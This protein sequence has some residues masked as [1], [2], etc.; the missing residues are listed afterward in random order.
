MSRLK[1]FQEKQKKLSRFQALK[2]IF[3]S[4]FM[5]AAVVVIAVV[6]IPKSPVGSIE[7]INTFNDAIS[8]TI[9]ITDSDNA[10]LEGTLKVELTNQF[11]TYEKDLPLGL[12][13]GLFEALQP[14]TPYTLKILA[15]KGY[16]LEVLDSQTVTTEPNP[17]GA[18]TGYNLL[19]DEAEYLIDYAIQYYIS[20]PEDDYQQILLRYAT[21]YSSEEL[22]YN[23]TE[24][25]LD[26]NTRE[27]TITSIYNYNVEVNLIL[28]AIN[29]D[30]E[31]IELDNIVFHTPYKI[32]ASMEIQQLTN[33]TVSFYV[34]PDYVDDV[35]F[36]LVLRQGRFIID[37][38][39]FMSRS[40][41]PDQMQDFE[42]MNVYAFSDLTPKKEYTVD[43]VA[44]YQDPYTLTSVD[45]LISSVDFTTTP[46]FDY[47]LDIQEF[48]DYYTVT[49]TTQDPELFYDVGYYTTYVWNIDD[50]WYDTH[51]SFAFETIGDTRQVSFEIYKST[52]PDYKI[53][54][55]I[56]HSD[57]Y[58]DF[59]ILD[60]II[61]QQEG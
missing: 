21:K 42:Q 26:E 53:E 33:D 6:V 5:T 49:I 55:G 59:V 51:E 10:I 7:S 3:S 23:Y 29:Q 28:I 45:K 1:Q 34:W 36:E 2:S 40:Y 11:E 17:G 30:S 50:Y 22:F 25:I 4:L 41:D 57:V 19:T 18:I 35:E 16:G 56:R 32:S 39:P 8:Y 12:S 47:T 14:D 60:T 9:N 52:N 46:D 44:H 20:D 48:M 27:T 37:Q 24:I 61:N 43:L 38:Q 15:D 31:E 58:Y 54:I 13:S